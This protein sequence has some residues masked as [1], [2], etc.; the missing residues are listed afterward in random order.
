MRTIE[1]KVLLLTIGRTI[2]LSSLSSSIGQPP[3]L[4]REAKPVPKS[5][6]E[7][8]IPVSASCAKNRAL[9]A[10]VPVSSLT[11]SAIIWPGTCSSS[12]SRETAAGKSGSATHP[13]PMLTET[14]T[15]HPEAA[16][17]LCW[18]SACLSISRL[19]S[20]IS[21]SSS[22]SEMND[23]GCR[24]PSSG[25]SH[26]ASSSAATSCPVDNSTSGWKYPIS[27]PS[28]SARGN[29]A[30]SC[31]ATSSASEAMLRY[32]PLGGNSTLRITQCN[33]NVVF[34]AVRPKCGVRAGGGTGRLEGR[35]SRR[36]GFPGWPARVPGRFPRSRSR[37]CS[38]A[39][40]SPAR[41]R[42]HRLR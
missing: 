15:S 19:N 25:C 9:M 42:C 8:W 2:E 37:W 16:Q 7:N 22:A 27:C 26:R 3:R 36:P 21:P 34:C 23:D 18:T 30:R 1:R 12:R 11:S 4:S 29:S 40:G 6:R 24:V 39:G 38:T 35:A 33:H 17:A 10:L 32:V 28:C 13:G 20:V 31:A 5:S 41:R 14:G